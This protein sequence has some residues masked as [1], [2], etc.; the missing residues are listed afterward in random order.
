MFMNVITGDILAHLH[1]FKVS[2]LGQGQVKV[3]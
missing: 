1:T 2:F 3:K